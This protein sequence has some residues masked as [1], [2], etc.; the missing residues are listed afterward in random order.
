MHSFEQIQTSKITKESIYNLNHH[1]L[2]TTI[3]NK[4]IGKAYETLEFTTKEKYSKEFP[5]KYK[6]NQYGYRG[7]DWNFEKSPAFFGCSFTFGIGVE[8]SVADLV[9]KKI[10]KV[11]PNLG[12]PG[13]SVINIIK[14]FVA[15]SSIHPTDYAFISLPPVSR[16]YKPV[17][18]YS[19]WNS[20][21]IIPGF[22]DDKQS[23]QITRMWTNTTDIAYTLDYIDWAE[24]IAQTRNI[25]LYWSAWNNETIRLLNSTPFSCLNPTLDSAISR[26]CTLGSTTGAMEERRMN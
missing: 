17:F 13:G 5:W 20:I 16:F 23:K 4:S 19:K 22:Q 10:N 12:I 1:I 11:V 18:E 21:N 2:C 25:K 24:Q 9:Q 6:I 15:F 3:K 8:Y 26:V 7:D 14:S